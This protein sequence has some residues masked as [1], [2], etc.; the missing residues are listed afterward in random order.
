MQFTIGPDVILRRRL[1]DALAGFPEDLPYE[2]EE[3]RSNL[4]YAK[5]LKE[6]AERYASVGD[7]GNYRQ[8]KV[9]D[10]K[11]V[12]TF[13]PPVQVTSEKQEELAASSRY[14]EETV[15]TDRAMKSLAARKVG[16]GFELDEALA[17][18]QARDDPLIF[19]KRRRVGDHTSQDMIAAVAACVIFFGDTSSPEYDWALDVLERIEGMEEQSDIHPESILSPHPTSFL[20]AS[21]ARLRVLNPSDVE[22]ARRLIRLTSYSLR[23]IR[24]QTLM[25]LFGD[26]EPA[27]AWATAQLAMGFS[28]RH[29]PTIKDDGQYDDSANEVADR[30]SVEEALAVVGTTRAGVLPELPPAWIKMVG[31]SRK[32]ISEESVWGDPDPSFSGNYAARYLRHL[33]IEYL[34]ENEAFKPLVEVTLKRFVGWTADRLMPSWRDRERRSHDTGTEHVEWTTFLGDYIARAAPYFE[35]QIVEKEFLAPFLVDDEDALHVLAPFVDVTVCRQVI[36]APTIPANTL[37]L[38]DLCVDRLV[39]DPTFDTSYYRAGEVHGSNLP[40][41]IKALLFIPVEKADGAA[42]F[43]NGD[44]REIGL[45][46]PII[47]RLVAQVGWSL[48]VMDNFLTLCERAGNAYPIGDFAVQIGSVLSSIED[49]HGSWGGTTIPA[50]IAGIVQRLSDSNFPLQDTQASNLLTILDSLID[51]GDRRS[52]ALEQSAAFKGVRREVK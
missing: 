20:I 37:A 18:S 5:G 24:D 31:P 49:G 6:D 13:E 45:V 38:L 16:D 40:R 4:D 51:L 11:V 50:R 30:K 36:D 26:P 32:A 47:T 42:R 29:R 44:W 35:I 33:P 15:I 21:L 10:D 41:L 2:I 43:A 8:H 22:L 52:V 7:I 23:E 48:V 9:E 28:I 14:I 27:V 34:C 3:D 39:R 12:V 19:R 1:A 46:M 25:A 17:L